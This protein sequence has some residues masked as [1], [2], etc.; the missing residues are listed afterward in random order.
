MNHTGQLSE[1]GS[2]PPP[3][4]GFFLGGN[5]YSGVELLVALGLLFVTSPFVEDLPHGNLIESLLLTLVMVTALL[6][7]GGQRRTFHVAMILIVPTVL[8]KWI[9]HVRPDLMPAAVFPATAVVF[10]GYVVAHLLRFVLNVSRVDTNVLCAG[11]SGYVLLGLLW[12]PLYVMVARLNPAAFAFPAG[13][14][15]A[16]PL[17]GFN[18]FYFSFMTLCT[19]GY[20]DITPV[21][22][23]ARM[24]AVTEAIAGLFYVAVLISRLVAVYSTTPPPANTDIPKK[25]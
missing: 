11:L 12:I 22:R 24:L 14:E 4:A 16:A 20:G 7:V 19:V 8:A 2:L 21:S 23:P 25:S 18:A 6:A 13:S 1:P 10:F 15:T 5:R 3:R 9:N 17:D